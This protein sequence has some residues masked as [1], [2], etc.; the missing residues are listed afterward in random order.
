MRWA[1]GV[2]ARALALHVALIVH[3]DPLFAFEL[4]VD[5]IV[6]HAR[7]PLPPEAR[8]LARA[9]HDRIARSPFLAAGDRYHVYLCDNP[10]LFSLLSEGLVGMGAAV[11]SRY[12][13]FPDAQLVAE[14]AERH[15]PVGWALML[16]EKAEEAG[17]AVDA[18]S[19]QQVTAKLFEVFTSPTSRLELEWSERN[20]AEHF[21]GQK[22]LE[23]LRGV[24]RRF[25]GGAKERIV[26][27]LK[28]HEWRL[29]RRGEERDGVWIET[30][31]QIT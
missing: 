31:K 8:G 16:E 24:L 21:V 22:G 26:G 5:D 9:A 30:G 15:A 17:A 14:H 29:P 7:E 27:T 20:E 13:S 18:G 12:Q 3:P 23:Q 28:S 25:E 10:S 1:L 4:D 11:S 19:K 6:L 2:L